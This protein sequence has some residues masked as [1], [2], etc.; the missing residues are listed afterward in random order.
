[1]NRLV[2]VLPPRRSSSKQLKIED[3][4]EDEALWIDQVVLAERRAEKPSPPVPRRAMRPAKRR[5]LA[6]ALAGIRR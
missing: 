2:L 3:K 4:D 5:A 1:V 6:R